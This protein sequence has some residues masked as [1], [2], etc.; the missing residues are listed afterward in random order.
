[1]QAE[2]LRL[3]ER[4]GQRRRLKPGV[5]N[6]HNKLYEK[7]IGKRMMKSKIKKIWIEFILSLSSVRFLI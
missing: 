4:G 5:S 1:M 3:Y 6:M 7:P 2:A